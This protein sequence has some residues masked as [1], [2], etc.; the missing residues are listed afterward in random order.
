MK[1][2]NEERYIDP[3][4][5][6]I[7][8]DGKRYIMGKTKYRM[9]DGIKH[10]DRHF[11]EEVS[12]SHEDG[13]LDEIAQKLKGKVSVEKII[14]EAIK[15]RLTGNQ[16]EKLLKL[17]QNKKAKVSEQEGCYGIVVDGKH[18]QIFE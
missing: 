16:R 18:F 12:L 2:I 3:H 9:V 6:H 14:K 8:I 1:K 15:K 10:I 17:L 7:V 13:I 4:R 5:S 11:L